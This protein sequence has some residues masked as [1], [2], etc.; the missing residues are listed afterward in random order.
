MGAKEVIGGLRERAYAA[1]E[2]RDRLREALIGPHD[3]DPR[4]TWLAGAVE[5]LRHFAARAEP[6]DDPDA[7]YMCASELDDMLR[8]LRSALAPPSGETHA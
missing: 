4:W 2:E 8:D 7:I 1:E 5:G 3:D 6:D